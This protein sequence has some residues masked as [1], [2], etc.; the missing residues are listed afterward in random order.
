MTI[1]EQQKTGSLK[2]KHWTVLSG[3]LAVGGNMD[4]LYGRVRDDV[5]NNDDGS[6]FAFFMSQVVHIYIYI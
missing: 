5:D 2:R 3:E 4:M 6:I 1:R